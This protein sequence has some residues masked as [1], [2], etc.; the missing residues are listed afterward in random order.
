VIDYEADGSAL[1]DGRHS[2]A[3]ATVG[4]VEGRGLSRDAEEVVRGLRGRAW[5]REAVARRDGCVR[6]RPRA[7]SLLRNASGRGL[8]EPAG[9]RTRLSD[10][11]VQRQ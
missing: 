7:S 4:E 3:R 9:E 6:R 5:G 2:W 1:A 10:K 8:R 11:S